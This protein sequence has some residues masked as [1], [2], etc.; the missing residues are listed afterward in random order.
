[1]AD[2]A[3]MLLVRPVRMNKI[4]YVSLMRVFCG[5]HIIA[6]AACMAD[7]A[8]MLLAPPVHTKHIGYVSRV[9]ICV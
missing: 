3:H 1:M 7:L 6:R 4:E 8:H 5:V 2:L 9:Y